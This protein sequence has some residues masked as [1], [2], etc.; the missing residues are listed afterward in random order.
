[1]RKRNARKVSLDVSDETDFNKMFSIIFP[2]LLVP[3]TMKAVKQEAL[4]AIF[5]LI[6]ADC[7][8]SISKLELIGAVYRVLVWEIRGEVGH[9]F[10]QSWRLMALNHWVEV[11]NIFYFNPYL[12]KIPILTSIFQM[13]WN[14]QLDQVWIIVVRKVRMCGQRGQRCEERN[15]GGILVKGV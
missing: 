14:H 13:G 12:G 10:R 4:L 2:I 3:F 1:M 7:G 9:K 8:G 6:D 15:V 11:S 5:K